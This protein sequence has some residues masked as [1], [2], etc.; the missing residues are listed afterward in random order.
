MRPGISGV[1]AASWKVAQ[2]L[3]TIGTRGFKEDKAFAL[4]EV[5]AA[6]WKMPKIQQAE[7]AER[8]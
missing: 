5:K 6:A 2:A 1:F 3:A 4:F 7:M 8:L